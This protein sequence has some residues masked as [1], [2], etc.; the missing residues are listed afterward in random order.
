MLR[1]RLVHQVMTNGGRSY[2]KIKLPPKVLIFWWRA[3]NNFLPTKGE[4]KRRHVAREDH[5]EACG[6]P[7]GSLYHVAFTCTF[8]KRFWQATREITGC[9]LPELHPVTW[10]TYLLSDNM[11]SEKDAALIICGVWSLW[12][13]RNARRHGKEQWNSRAVVAALVEELI[14]MDLEK[15]YEQGRLEKK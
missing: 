12:S 2:G 6:E 15:A 10:M 9:R 1:M 3:I 13:G 4:L 14:C 11:C 7:R 5:C 8:A